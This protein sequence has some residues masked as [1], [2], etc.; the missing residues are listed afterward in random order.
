MF[1]I[2]QTFSRLALALAAAAPALAGENPDANLVRSHCAACHTFGKGEPH[3]LGPNLYGLLG[4]KAASARGYAYSPSFIQALGGQVWTPELL[5]AWLVDTQA[6]TPGTG[7]TYFLDDP[8]A[9]AQLVK[10]FEN[11][12]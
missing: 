12:R 6:F 2:R 9:R 10:Y 5:N 8:S 11:R 7:M 3:G 1:Q 4:R